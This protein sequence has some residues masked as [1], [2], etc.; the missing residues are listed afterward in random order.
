MYSIRHLTGD[1]SEMLNPTFRSVNFEHRGPMV[2]VTTMTRL[3]WSSNPPSRRQEFT[4]EGIEAWVRLIQETPN[5]VI[6]AMRNEESTLVRTPWR[7]AV[8]GMW[9][10]VFWDVMKFLPQVHSGVGHFHPP[11]HDILDLEFGG[12][13]VVK[14]WDTHMLMLPAFLRSGAKVSMY[15]GE[16]KLG[17]FD[18]ENEFEIWWLKQGT[19]VKFT[20][21]GE[22]EELAAVLS[23][24]IL[25]NGEL[26]PEDEIDYEGIGVEVNLE[27]SIEDD[28]HEVTVE[29]TSKDN[30]AAKPVGNQEYI[31]ENSD[32][33]SEEE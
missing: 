22:G 16:T 23:L 28:D 5:E 26:D 8:Y 11:N 15:E 24:G 30:D 13:G 1:L 3:A 31:F 17:T 18:G 27:E 25:C 29:E 4:Q 21:E 32:D 12:E 9:N 19:E 7:M 33:D 2:I 14:K 10:H 6:L 20:V